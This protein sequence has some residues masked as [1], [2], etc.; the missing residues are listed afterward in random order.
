MNETLAPVLARG[1]TELDVILRA[2][3]AGGAPTADQL[4]GS[5]SPAELGNAVRVVQHLG[6]VRDVLLKVNAAYIASAA[7]DEAM[8]GEPPFLLQGS[9]R[10]L[11]RIAS[12]VV[13]AM[14]PD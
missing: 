1:R 4:S 3:A 14:T 13:P 6:Q 7:T 10:N 12:R 9:Y 11:A 5:Y 8:R 2:V